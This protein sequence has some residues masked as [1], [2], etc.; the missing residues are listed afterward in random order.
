MFTNRNVYFFIAFIFPFLPIIFFLNKTNFPQLFLTE[1]IY[2][3]IFQLLVFFFLILFSI[4]IYKLLSKKISLSLIQFI[5]V[6]SLIFYL[7]F[8]YRKINLIFAYFFE[9]INSYLDNILSL[10]LYIGIYFLIIRFIKK[11]NFLTFLSFYLFINLLLLFINIYQFNAVKLKFDDFK[12]FQTSNNLK[13][14]NLEKV[15]S[16]KN[17]ENIFFI[18]L[19]GIPSIDIAKKMKLIENE[20][21]IINQLNDLGLNYVENFSSN[22]TRTFLSLESILNSTYPVLEG[23]PKK[24]INRK[25]FYP[26]SLNSNEN[27]RSKILELTNRTLIWIGSW[28][29][30]C[31]KNQ[32]SPCFVNYDFIDSI[33]LKVFPIYRESI[34]IIL[35]NLIFSDLFKDDA[36]NVSFEFLQN[37]TNYLSSKLLLNSPKS[38]YL[39][40]VDS[41]HAPHNF[42]KNCN[43]IKKYKRDLTDD[44][45]FIHFSY[46]YGCTLDLVFNWVS[47]INSIEKNNLIFIFGDHGM[48]V[49][50]K[51]MNDLE[52]DY[53][54]KNYDAD[55]ET[56]FAYQIP[57]RCKNLEVPKSLVNLMRFSLNCA[58]NL[59]LEYLEDYKF[60]SH[61]DVFI[62]NDDMVKEYVKE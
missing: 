53:G 20:N 48:R 3:I 43:R 38:I 51:R 10:F 61:Y 23:E 42:D 59:N 22:Y 45:N 28:R 56:F 29:A 47:K 16:S 30:N 55:F 9:E 41:P 62:A 52:K 19:D 37:E 57:S 27:I 50:K 60:L 26:F 40:H 4:F 7:L 18:I 5:S 49:D 58:E 2:I 44:Q 8:F 36:A 54:I 21:K 17:N 6:N 15:S 14:L 11:K 32:V 35:F 25:I 46:A 33:Y 24:S 39:I 31:K 13:N 1:I 12:I 34:F